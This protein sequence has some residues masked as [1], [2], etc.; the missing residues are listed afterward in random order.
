MQSARQPS[1]VLLEFRI[2]HLY[3]LRLA[4][5]VSQESNPSMNVRYLSHLAVTKTE[6]DC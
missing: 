6:K 3:K 2:M 5:N 1:N 4:L